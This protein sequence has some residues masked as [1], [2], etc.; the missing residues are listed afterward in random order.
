MSGYGH[1]ESAPT[2]GGVFR[3]P[4][5]GC[6]P[7]YRRPSAALSQTVRHPFRVCSLRIRWLNMMY[8]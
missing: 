8:L 7:R 4:F 2:P 3:N 1:D 6:S 5:R